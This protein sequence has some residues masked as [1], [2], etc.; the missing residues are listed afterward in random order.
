MQAGPRSATS[1]PSHPTNG[2][3]FPTCTRASG[4]YLTGASASGTSQLSASGRT[5]HPAPVPCP[6]PHQPPLPVSGVLSQEAVWAGC[7]VTLSRREGSAGCLSSPGK[8]PR[9]HVQKEERAQPCRP[10]L[11][12]PMGERPLPFGVTSPLGL[13]GGWALGG[14]HPR[15]SGAG[16]SG[17]SGLFSRVGP[18]RRPGRFCREVRGCLGPI[19][20][21][22]GAAGLPPH[23]SWP[24]SSLPLCAPVSPIILLIIQ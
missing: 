20:S 5:R 17:Q 24:P 7:S 12:I 9:R 10:Q 19:P 4:T 2:L 23:L 13:P 6:L 21:S 14:G 15:L 16:W 22:S 8:A 18:E 1:E 11:P 3:R